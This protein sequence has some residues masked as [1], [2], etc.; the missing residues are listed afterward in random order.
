M[1][2]DWHRLPIENRRL[3]AVVERPPGADHRYDEVFLGTLSD[4]DAPELAV[5]RTVADAL[6]VPFHFS[7]SQRADLDQPRWWDRR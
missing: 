6:G 2:A 4:A 1:K 3:V 5:A 7:Q